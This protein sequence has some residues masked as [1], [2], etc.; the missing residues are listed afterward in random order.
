MPGVT[1]S[2]LWAGCRAEGW[3]G[4]ALGGVRC[5]GRGGEACTVFWVTVSIR[6]RDR[7]VKNRYRCDVC[8]C[9]CVFI[10]FICIWFCIELRNIL[11]VIYLISLPLK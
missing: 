7:C 2:V 11:K 6:C 1:F 9:L 5:W 3:A 4:V 10:L 8:M